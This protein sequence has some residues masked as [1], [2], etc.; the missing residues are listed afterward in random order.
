MNGLKSFREDYGK[1]FGT[2][3][4]NSRD[5]ARLVSPTFARVRQASSR[6]ANSSSVSEFLHRRS[7]ATQK[8]NHHH[9]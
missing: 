2:E 9:D 6:I 8:V 7:A 3:R 1:A 4:S 5:S